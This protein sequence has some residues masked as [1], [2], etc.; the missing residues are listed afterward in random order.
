MNAIF[1]ISYTSRA[2]AGTVL[3]LAAASLLLQHR[4][5]SAGTKH[6]TQCPNASMLTIPPEKT[7]HYPISLLILN[8]QTFT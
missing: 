7:P 6:T 2:S 1:R 8:I 3:S 4:F 5:N